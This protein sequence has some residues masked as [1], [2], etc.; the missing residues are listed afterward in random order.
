MFYFADE[1]SATNASNTFRLVTSEKGNP[2]FVKAYIR[3]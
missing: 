1:L 3:V 2:L